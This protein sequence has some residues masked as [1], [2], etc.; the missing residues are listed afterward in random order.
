MTP[1]SANMERD[2]DIYASFHRK[3]SSESLARL[4]ANYP[5]HWRRYVRWSIARADE[6]WKMTPAKA[7]ADIVN[8]PVR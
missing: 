2:L 3:Q 6:G 1:F 7:A 8:G 5:E 4:S